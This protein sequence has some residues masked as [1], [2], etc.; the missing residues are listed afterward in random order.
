M[1][2]PLGL[3]STSAFPDLAPH[4]VFEVVDAEVDNVEAG[5]S[6]EQ[7]PVVLQQAVCGADD[8]PQLCEYEK[9]RQRNIKERDEAMREALEEIDVAKQDMRDNAPG[10]QKRA[11]EEEEGVLME[12][13]NVESVVV[14]ARRERNP[15]CSVVEFDINERSRKRGRGRDSSR[16]QSRSP[17]RKR[18][19]KAISK[20]E[21]PSST[22]NL[23]PR[24]HIIS[25]WQ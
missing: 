18:C 11:A 5:P 8:P 25:I 9:L 20:P 7:L 14:D 19:G 22:H 2:N 21:S 3:S 17:V 23:H 10:A 12:R 24:K 6:V 4:E 15:V 16:A 13:Q 1:A